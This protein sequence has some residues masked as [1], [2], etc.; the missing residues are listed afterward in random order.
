MDDAQIR[1]EYF[2]R[3]HLTL[4][5]A[6]LVA[7]VLFAPAIF[8]GPFQKRPI[9]SWLVLTIGF[10]VMALVIACIHGY[11]RYEKP[12]FPRSEKEKPTPVNFYVLAFILPYLFIVTVPDIL[13]GEFD[14]HFK[15]TFN[16]AFFAS[17]LPPTIWF[18]KWRLKLIES[19]PHN[20]PLI[21]PAT[22]LPA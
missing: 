12:L 9:G 11:K 17:V 1:R 15:L 13:T 5:V 14:L 8:L 10:A 21:E 7:A 18:L 20:S 22:R 16:L 6:V 19:L 2:R 3:F 4:V